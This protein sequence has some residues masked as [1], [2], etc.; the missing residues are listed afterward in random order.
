MEWKIIHIAETDST[1][2]WLTSH[3]DSP[4]VRGALTK[5]LSPC[6]VVWADY[7][8]AGKGQG[9]NSW[10]SERG[11]NLL[12]SIL[13]HPQDIPANRQFQISMA[14]SLAIADALGE[15]IGDVSIKWPNDIY[16]R[17]AK[18]GGI[19]IENRLMGQ[20]IK[21]SIIGVGINVNQRQFHS[22]AP[23]PVSLWQIHGHETDRETLL[24]SIL[25]RFSLYINKDVKSRYVNMLYRRKG[26]HPYCDKDGAFMAEFKDVE[27]DGHLVLSK[28][29]GQQCRYAFKEIQFVI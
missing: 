7:Q 2:R 17:N 24:R 10:E 4:F 26:F 16:W 29:N 18:I 19:L 3:G 14:V 20:T 23:N 8:T 6:E 1:N 15:Q 27:D 13:Y 25:D 9:T 12:F 11:K 28:E 21:D 5:G 22:D